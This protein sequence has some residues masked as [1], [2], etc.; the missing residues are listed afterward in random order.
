MFDVWPAKQMLEVDPLDLFIKH[1]GS[2]RAIESKYICFF[3]QG[4]DL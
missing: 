2:K 1:I 3:K 4:R